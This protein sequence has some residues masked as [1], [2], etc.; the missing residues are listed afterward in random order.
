MPILV[1]LCTLT[2]HADSLRIRCEIGT[3]SK[4]MVTGASFSLSEVEHGLAHSNVGRSN[5]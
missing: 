1:I 5:G 4:M 3:K 2:V